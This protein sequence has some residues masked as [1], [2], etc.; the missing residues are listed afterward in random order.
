MHRLVLVALL[1]AICV[2]TPGAQEALTTNQR[3]ADLVQL[4]S[5][6]AK[7]YAPYEWK[8]DVIGFDLYRLT[9]WLQRIHHTDDLDFQ[10]ALIDYVASL[11]DAHD[12]IFFPSNFYRVARF[13]GGHLRRQGAHRFGGQG[14]VACGAVSVRHRRRAR[15]AG[16]GTGTGLIASFGKYAVGRQSAEHGTEWLPVGSTAASSNSCRTRL[17]CGDTAIASIRLT[18]HRCIEQLFGS[19]GSR[20]ALASSRRGH[21][22]VRA[23]GTAVS[24]CAPDLDPRLARPRRRQRDRALLHHGGSP[25]RRQHPAGLHG[26]DSARC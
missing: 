10:E 26:A 1:S 21:S 25:R 2:A 7:H 8:R 18:E 6:Y 22:R 16:R 9:P 14:G 3:D 12:G 23:A 4:A 15:C 13:H 5:M 19:H 11:N 20:A 24:F 17:S